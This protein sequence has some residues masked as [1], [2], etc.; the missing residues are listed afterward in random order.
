MDELVA[1]DRVHVGRGQFSEVFMFTHK[2]ADIHTEFVVIEAAVSGARLRVSPGH[3]IYVNGGLAAAKEV[4]VG[5]HIELADGSV[6]TVAA[7][8]KAVFEGLYNPQTLQG[9]IVVDG[10]RASTYTTAVEP[11]VAH[12]ILSPLRAVYRVLGWSTSAFNDGSSLAAV[13]PAGAALC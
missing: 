4:V 9:D 10:V 7:V 12:A 1:G 8:S 5:D 11:A 13:A 6:D 3:Y 2:T